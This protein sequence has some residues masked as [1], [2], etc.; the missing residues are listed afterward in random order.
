MAKIPEMGKDTSVANDFRHFMENA[1]F[2]VF[3][4][5]RL[6]FDT[7][8]PFL[9]KK[10]TF[11]HSQKSDGKVT[12]SD[13][14]LDPFSEPFSRTILTLKETRKGMGPPEETGKKGVPGSAHFLT[15]F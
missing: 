13:P 14:F 3:E 8:W 11:G 5:S 15:P 9:I 2:C 10:P 12:K 4:G 6:I 7:F 1:R